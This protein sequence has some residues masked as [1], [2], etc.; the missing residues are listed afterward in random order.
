M[1]DKQKTTQDS[2]T[3]SFNTSSC[4]T[5]M[6]KMMG[7]QS[8]DCAETMSQTTKQQGQGCCAEM[9]TQMMTMFGKAQSETEEAT[10]T[11]TA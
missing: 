3:A 8:C 2:Q 5:M 6:E 10:T 7:Q 1:T 4:M 11:K 9:M